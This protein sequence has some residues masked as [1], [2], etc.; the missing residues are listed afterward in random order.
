M[1]LPK[2]RIGKTR[3]AKRRTHQKATMPNVVECPQCKGPMLSHQACKGCGY[4]SGR[5]AI[6]IKTA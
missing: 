2:H 5:T 6:A 3:K 4:Y 1:A